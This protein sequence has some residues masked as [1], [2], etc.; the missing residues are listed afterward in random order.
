MH[1]YVYMG[2]LWANRLSNWRHTGSIWWGTGW[3]CFPRG[4]NPSVDAESHKRLPRKTV[5]PLTRAK[6]RGN[7]L[8]PSVGPGRAPPGDWVTK[9]TV[10]WSE[11][12]PIVSVRDFWEGDDEKPHVW[13]LLTWGGLLCFLPKYR[14]H[15]ITEYFFFQCTLL[16]QIL[17]SDLKKNY[18]QEMYTLIQ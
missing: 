10:K 11:A 17:G 16:F 5:A 15:R 6:P 7:A 8:E 2:W 14:H 9:K 4:W 1:I 12:E 3:S 13:F 18:N